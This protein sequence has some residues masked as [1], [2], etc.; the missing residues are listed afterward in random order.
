MSNNHFVLLV[1]TS[2]KYWALLGGLLLVK[3][4]YSNQNLI[5]NLKKPI[6]SNIFVTGMHSKITF[7]QHTNKKVS[8][9]NVQAISEEIMFSKFLSFVLVHLTFA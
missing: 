5:N 6:R 4:N 2:T 9:V 1:A 3:S 8:Y 7:H